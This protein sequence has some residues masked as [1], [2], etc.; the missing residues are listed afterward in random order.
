[1]LFNIIPKTHAIECMRVQH[2]M[3]NSNHSG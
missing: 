1:M 2:K 3:L